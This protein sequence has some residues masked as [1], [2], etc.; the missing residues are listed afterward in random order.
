MTFINFSILRYYF[1]D[2]LSDEEKFQISE[3]FVKREIPVIFLT[4]KANVVDKVKG[5]KL[6]AEVNLLV[7]SGG[8]DVDLFSDDI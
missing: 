5:L 3:E 7:L 8:S 1:T 6:G 4:A 2:I